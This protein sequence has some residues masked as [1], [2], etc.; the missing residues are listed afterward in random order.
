MRLSY[1][2]WP[3]APAPDPRPESQELLKRIKSA[4][5][6][7]ETLYEDLNHQYEDRVYRYY[8]GAKTSFP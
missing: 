7:L 4:L 3:A 5:P 6:Q 8:Q 2:V 1:V